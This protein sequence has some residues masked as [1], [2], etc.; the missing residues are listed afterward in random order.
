M[1]QEV[2]Y[3]FRNL[4][5][6][7]GFTLVAIV[8]LALAI[9]ATTALFSLI[10]GAYFE[11]LPYPQPRELL[12]LSAEFAKMG[13]AETPISGPEFL[14]LQEQAHTLA[15]MTAL[16][17][18]SFNLTSEGD[19]VRFRGLRATASLFE[20]LRVQPFLGRVFTKEEQR[21]GNDRVAV[22]SYRIW[23][24]ALGGAPNVIGRQLQLNDV[25]YTILG[26]MPPRFLYGDND[27]WVPLSL[28]LA[29]Q[30]RAVRNIYCHAR[31]APNATVESV[32]AELTAIAHRIEQDFGGTIPE[33][34][35]W[36]L[37]SKPLIDDVLRDVKSALGILIGAVGCVLLIAC[38]NISNLQL[39][40]NVVCEREMGSTFG[41]VAL[42][43][44]TVALIASYIPAIRATRADPM[45][46]PGHG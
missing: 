41:F 19:A 12:T 16:V 46:A 38:A 29:A 27:V 3:A 30:D 15:S 44:A 8:T 32:N 37:K 6:S 40:R 17:G 42:A 11:G 18:T 10:K 5:K 4:R 26:V 1:I 24:R 25:A 23:Q 14:A 2:R 36:R 7:P 13:K 21:E 31:L 9:G 33:Y 28:D 45:I 35:G 39:A 34:A 22:I 43:L 20:M